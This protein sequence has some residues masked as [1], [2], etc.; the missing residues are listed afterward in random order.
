MVLLAVILLLAGGVP[1]VAPLPPARAGAS[2]VW[3]L[4]ESRT[5]AA[6]GEP[7]R[8][9]AANLTVRV[10]DATAGAHPSTSMARRGAVRLGINPIVTLE[11]QL[12]Y[13]RK[14]GIKWLRCTAD[15]RI[16]YRRR[17]TRLRCAEPRPSDRAMPGMLTQGGLGG[18][19]APLASR[20]H[21]II[22]THFPLNLPE[23]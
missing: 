22:P 16:N 8:C 20:L 21:S 19:P 23:I 5:A 15:N 14:T 17:A 10:V 12:E 6:G 4:L 1:P 3:P 2:V 11:K 13:D 9:A 18:R 7:A